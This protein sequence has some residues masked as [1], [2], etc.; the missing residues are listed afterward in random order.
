MSCWNTEAIVTPAFLLER[1]GSPTI[2]AAHTSKEAG[3]NLEGAAAGHCPFKNCLSLKPG[4]VATAGSGTR[5]PPNGTS[6]T[7]TPNN[8][9]TLRDPHYQLPWGQVCFMSPPHPFDR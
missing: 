5:P 1:A 2:L 4:R 8:K 9:H 3:Q 6:S 7:F